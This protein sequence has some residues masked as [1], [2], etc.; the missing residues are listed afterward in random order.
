MGYGFNE[1]VYQNALVI[2]LKE[3]GFNIEEQRQI[4]VYYH[5]QLVGEYLADIVV[6]DVILL[7]LKAT[8]QI[9]D[10]HEAQLLNYLKA[11]N[12]EVGYVL[13]FGPTYSFKR[14]IYDMS[15]KAL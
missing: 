14:K 2:A 7:E 13:N 4:Q 8:K 1:K 9:I 6:N 5:G 12:F 15:A 3:T 10:E 11:T